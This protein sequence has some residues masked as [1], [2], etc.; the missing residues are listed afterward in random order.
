MSIPPIRS[1]VGTKRFIRSWS[2]IAISRVGATT[3]HILGLRI[4]N[5]SVSA[6]DFPEP[7]F[8]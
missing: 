7:F 4:S 2:W 8:D 6:R 5:K 3:I 1:V